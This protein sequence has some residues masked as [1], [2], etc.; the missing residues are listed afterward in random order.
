MLQN[1]WSPDFMWL[2]SRPQGLV[3]LSRRIIEMRVTTEKNLK[4][5]LQAA[6]V[7]VKVESGIIEIRIPLLHKVN[8][9]ICIQSLVRSTT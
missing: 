3:K 2:L 5:S 1:V 7:V 4:T 8:L 6:A 9:Q